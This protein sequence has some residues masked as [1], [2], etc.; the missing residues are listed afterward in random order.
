MIG[1]SLLLEVLR[2]DFTIFFVELITLK[3][4]TEHI[5]RKKTN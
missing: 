4:G 3:I 5:E 2:I 1:W